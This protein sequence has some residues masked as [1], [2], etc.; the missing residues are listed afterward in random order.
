MRGIEVGGRFHEIRFSINALAE[1]EEMSG[2]DIEFHLTR[3]QSASSVSSMRWLFGC[4]CRGANPAIGV[5]ACGEVLETYLR[6]GGSLTKLFEE[7]TGAAEESGFFI[8][9]LRAGEES[10]KTQEKASA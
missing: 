4:G 2:H 3:I 7:I 6:E 9:A 10:K 5:N 8:A 1:L